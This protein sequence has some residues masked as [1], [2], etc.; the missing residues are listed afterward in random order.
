MGCDKLRYIDWAVE[1]SVFMVF[2]FVPISASCCVIH[3]L[4]GRV[5]VAETAEP[6]SSAQFCVD[7]Q[8]GVVCTDV[9]VSSRSTIETAID[10]DEPGIIFLSQAGRATC[11]TEVGRLTFDAAFS[12]QMLLLFAGLFISM[13]T[14]TATSWVASRKAAHDWREEYESRLRRFANGD[15]VSP[16]PAPVPHVWRLERHRIRKVGYG[17]QKELAKAGPLGTLRVDERINLVERVLEH[18]GDRIA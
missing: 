14:M 5:V 17:A 7:N 4:G 16:Y 11:A 18:L 9:V 13:A 2:I 10:D 3:T 8:K 6:G 12:K 1:F 15:D